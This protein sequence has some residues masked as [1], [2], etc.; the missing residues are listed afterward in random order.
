M[1]ERNLVGLH[2]LEAV[3]S[4]LQRVR[5]AH[6]TN[7]SYEAA[8]IQW[9]WS[10]VRS[11]DQFGQ[12]FWFDDLGRPEAAV[13]AT[14]F[15]DGSSALYE[16]PVLVVSLMPDA[17]PDWI[18]HVVQRGLAHAAS[19]GIDTVELEIGKTDTVVRDVLFEHGFTVKEGGLVESWIAADSRPEI[20]PLAEGYR[21]ATRLDTMH[22]PHHMTHPR[23][24]NVEE[25]LQE[26]SLYR[27]D[28]DLVVLDSDDN[29]A[30][31]GLFWYDR[32]TSTGVV[33]PMRTEDDHQRRGLARHVL[34]TGIDLLAKAG[35]ERIKICFAPDNPGASH[36]YL[37][38]G[39]E[40]HRQ[41]DVVSGSIG[42][43]AP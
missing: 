18:A 9:W 25:R 21:L 26:T 23:R 13:F 6:P 17:T 12:L 16:E 24:P 39:F 14:D 28:L 15:G 10:M 30:A 41:T 11:T 43:V 34:T 35:A 32:V 31:Y 20:S 42:A 29:A 36:L 7:G 1:Q 37:S 3:T 33:E 22:L 40:P 5:S 27:P 38:V 4:L 8:E 2:Y 19:A